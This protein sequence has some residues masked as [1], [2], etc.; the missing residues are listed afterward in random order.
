MHSFLD[1]RSSSR[2]TGCQQNS[3]PCSC[4][5]EGPTFLLAVVRVLARG[6]LLSLLT[7][8]S[9][10]LS[11]QWETLSFCNITAG[12][13]PSITFTILLASS[14]PWDPALKRRGLFKA[15]SN[16]QRSLAGASS[17]FTGLRP[18]PAPPQLPSYFSD[19]EYWPK[20]NRMDMRT[21][22]ES[23]R[24]YWEEGEKEAEIQ[25]FCSLHSSSESLTEA[26]ALQIMEAQQGDDI[27]VS[28]TGYS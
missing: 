22:R 24:R 9:F 7:N 11:G 17:I 28:H 27:A 26:L 8:G 3:V 2:L 18:S 21:R 12:V 15:V 25:A 16:L 20:C 13:T 10:H 4:R 19:L 23:D 6:P 5:A 14:Q 1:L